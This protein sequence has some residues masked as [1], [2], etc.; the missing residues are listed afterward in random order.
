LR[1]LDAY[2]AGAKPKEIG[3]ALFSNPPN[4]CPTHERAAKLRDWR[5]AARK[6]RDGGYRALTA[7]CEK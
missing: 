5:K 6:L 1:I 2:D 4:Y 7:L 3:E